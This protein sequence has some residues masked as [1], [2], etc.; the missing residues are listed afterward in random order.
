[1][2]R[3]ECDYSE[4]AHPRIL[5]RLLETNLE[6]SPGYGMDE[7]CRRGTSDRIPFPLGDCADEAHGGTDGGR[8]ARD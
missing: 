8:G 4:G 1:M 7:H 3:F 6:Q 2:L 5:N